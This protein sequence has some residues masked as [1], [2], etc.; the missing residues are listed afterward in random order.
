MTPG[1]CGGRPR[2]AG[3][4]VA[5]DFIARFVQSGATPDEI[6]S[7]YPQLSLAA[8]HDAISYYY[9]HRDDIDGFLR[10]NTLEDTLSQYGLT[11]AGD[12]VIRFTPA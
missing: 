3:T 2:I 9:D 1:I 12:G 8:V 10:D 4:R 6:V 5:V 11:R 7:S